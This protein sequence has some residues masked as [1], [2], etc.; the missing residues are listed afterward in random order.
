MY[1]LRS[2]ALYSTEVGNIALMVSK[3]TKIVA[4]LTQTT[5]EQMVVCFGLFV[6]V[7]YF[8]TYTFFQERRFE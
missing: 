1:F 2:Q 8:E 4:V 5:P 3:Q 6:I 7:H